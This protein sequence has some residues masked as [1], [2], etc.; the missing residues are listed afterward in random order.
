MANVSDIF[1]LSR[2]SVDVP[3]ALRRRMEPLRMR[4][5]NTTDRTT[6]PIPPSHCVSAR[7]NIRL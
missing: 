2:L 3:S 7:H 5:R 1:G 6:I 4:E